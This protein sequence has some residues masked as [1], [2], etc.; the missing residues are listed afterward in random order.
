MSKFT[1][2]LH[3]LLENEETNN[4]IKKAMSSYPIYEPV[5][6][7]LYGYIPTRDELNKK[8]LNHYR[9][10]EIGSET[11]GRF[12]YNLE[13]TLNE[14]MPIYNQMYKS[15]DIMNGIDDIFGNVDI[16]ETFDEERT[17]NTSATSKDN[18]TGSTTG[19]TNQTTDSSTTSHVESTNNTDTDMNSNSRSA[20]SVTPQS[21]LQAK[22]LNQITAASEMGWSED[23]NSSNSSSNDESD[24]TSTNEATST[25]SSETSNTQNTISESD[26]ETLQ[27]NKHTLT[28][29]GNQGVNTYAHDML[30]FRQLFLNIEQ[31][32]IN[33]PELAS[34][35][36]LVW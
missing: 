10:Y 18:I 24:T 3:D 29:K 34:C 20:K 17:D 4:L 9:F 16:T 8:I 26:R 15:V 21:Q 30:E 1:E 7:E 22:T 11:V 13:M 6:K 25:G 31:Q 27:N 19:S 28:R 5:H 2:V 33:D 12:L 32:I 23:S 35:F 36:M 14:I